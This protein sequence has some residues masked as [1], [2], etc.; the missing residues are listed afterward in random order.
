MTSLQPNPT[1]NERFNA[2]AANWD[3]N[4]SV[5]EATQMAFQTLQPTITALADQKRAATGAS[6]DVLEVGCGT[7]LL[8]LRVAP[9]VK[10]IVA[11][12][13]AAGMIEM[14][15]AKTRQPNAPRNIRP[16]CQLLEDAEDP[17]LP[18]AAAAATS[19]DANPSSSS[20]PRRKFDLIL[21]HLTMHHVPDLRPFLQTLLACLTPGG[22]V[23]LTDFEDFGPE[24]IRFHPPTKLE[25]VER[26]GIP[27]G[28]IEEL[29]TEV[30]FVEVRVW[31]GWTQDK[32][33]ED[34]EDAER[35]TMPFPFLVCEGVRRLD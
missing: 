4:P 31:V 1:G 5:Q 11:V 12:D 23:A 2:E 3:N 10:E 27:R 21:S 22:R 7:G 35:P 18:P 24:A 30:G 26:H 34:W 33:V 20:S 9:L 6:L 32:N 25:G 15:T 13:T 17:V 14:L 16:I 28:W 29:M 19:D 8:T